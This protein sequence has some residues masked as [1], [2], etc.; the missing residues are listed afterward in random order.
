LDPAGA[1]ERAYHMAREGR[2]PDLPARPITIHSIDVLGYEWPRLRLDISC[3]KGTYIRSLARDI[4]A[5]LGAGGVLTALRRTESGGVGD[6]PFTVD[7]ATPLDDLPR[8]MTQSD[9][10][11]LPG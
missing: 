9:L 5:A 6:R 2:A 3:G 4:G 11:Q 10:R 1:G 7:E 8:A